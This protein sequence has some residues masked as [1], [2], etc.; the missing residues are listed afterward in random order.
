[1]ADM[2]RQAL[3]QAELDG[4]LDG[5]ERAALARMLLAE[6]ETRA[7][8]DQLHRLGGHLDSMGQVEPPPTLAGA[9]LGRLPRAT[10][11]AGRRWSASHWRLAALV[12]GVATAGSIV[13]Q[14]VQ[15]PSPGTN[16]TS[17]TL[18]SGGPVTVD[19]VTLSGGT[20]SGRASLVREQ[21]GLSMTLEMSSAEP[22]DVVVSS[23]GKSFTIN[24]LERSSPG[25]VTHQIVPL[26][27]AAAPGQAVE[28]TFL[29]QG[30]PVARATLHAPASP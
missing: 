5:T 10:S 11:S 6:P 28:L 3:I 29:V 12:A 19:T 27:G 25:S 23:G 7:L 18:A 24:V 8:R 13:Y 21:A 14:F 15:G 17:G 2:D 9:I 26:P 22:L 1:M 20:V 30:R 4:E 16:E